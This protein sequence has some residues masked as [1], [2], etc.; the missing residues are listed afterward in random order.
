MLTHRHARVRA[1][2]CTTKKQR[3]V[4]DDTKLSVYSVQQEGNAVVLV[5]VMKLN[6][7]C[8]MQRISPLEQL[9]LQ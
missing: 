2:F 8:E 6:T 1:G 4:K 9:V 5:G 3:L 7:A